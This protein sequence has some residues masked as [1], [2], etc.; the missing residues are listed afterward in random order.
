MSMDDD[1]TPIDGDDSGDEKPSDESK[2]NSQEEANNQTPDTNDDA[3]IEEDA[4]SSDDESLDESDTTEPQEPIELPKLYW[5]TQ[6]Q[7]DESSRWADITIALKEG[8]WKYS[9]KILTEDS[10]MICLL[11]VN[12]YAQGGRYYK[13]DCAASIEGKTGRAADDAAA[14]RLAHLVDAHLLDEMFENGRTRYYVPTLILIHHF[15]P[16]PINKD[17][18]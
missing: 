14:R 5:V 13:K 4:S 16:N 18:S 11:A 12:I 1:G 6:Q 8:G 10:R 7:L 2:D 9:D 17:L 3:P 15:M